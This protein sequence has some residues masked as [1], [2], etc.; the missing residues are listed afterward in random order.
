M[1]KIVRKLSVIIAAIVLF[2]TAES[3]ARS[4]NLP[5][6]TVN[7][8][9]YVDSIGLL[10][11]TPRWMKRYLNSLIKGNIDRSRE[12]KF[13]VSVG[14]S[15]SYTREASFGIGA[16]ASGLYRADRNDTIV[17]ASDV[18]AS[19][20]ASINGF[21]VFTVKG[22]NLFSDNRSRINYKLEVYKSISISGV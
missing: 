14:I 6:S 17:G 21:Y 3:H 20:N 16:M 19:I 12:K 7:N 22:N 13:D 10:R 9:V 2:S 15:P 4:F 18:F 8:S 11:G 5:D 1:C